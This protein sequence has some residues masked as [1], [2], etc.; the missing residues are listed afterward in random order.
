MKK[1]YIENYL[2]G[3]R[4]YKELLRLRVELQKTKVCKGEKVRIKND[5]E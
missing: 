5:M 3:K 4:R 1:T 2:E